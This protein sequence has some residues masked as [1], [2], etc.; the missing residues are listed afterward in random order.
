MIA[1]V[2][3]LLQEKKYALVK[4]AVLEMNAV[5]IAEVFA[6]LHELEAPQTA[7]RL[8][9]LMP[10]ELAAET[11]SYMESD[12]Q[13]SI[14][15]AISDN[16]L[17]FILD[18]M[19]MDDYVDLIEEMPANVVKRVL[20]NSSPENRKLINQY[21]QYPEDSA[22]SLMTNEYVYLKQTLTVNQ[23]LAVIRANGVDKETINKCYVLDD[24]HHLDGVVSLRDLI[25]ADPHARVGDIMRTNVISVNTN[26]DQEEVA[27]MFSKYD[28]LSMPVVD[29]ENRLVGIITID[30]VVD[31]VQDE[32]TEDFEKMAGIVP[33]EDTYLKTPVFTIFRSRIMWLMVLMVS[34]M[35]SGALITHFEGAISTLPILVSFIPMLIGTGCG[36]PGI[37]ASRTIE[38]ERDRRMTIMTTT[39]IPCGAKVPFIGMIAGALFG[40]SA[41]VSTSAYFIGMAAIIISG[42]MLKKTKMFAGDPAPF[43][44]EL[45]AY[46]WPT[47]G[48]VLRSMWERGWSFIK[49]AGT[50]ILLSTI[51]VWFTSR[52][53]W[54]DGQFGMLEEDQISASILAKIG[55]AIAW[56]FAPLG[57]GNWQATVASITGLVAKENIVGTLGILYGGG[58]ASVYANLAQAFTGL[59]GYSFLVFNLLCAPCFAAI[60]AIKREMNNRG[61]T[62]FAIGYQCGFAYCIALMINQFGNL[63]TGNANFLGV[64]VAV[65]FLVGMVY[66]LFKPYKEAAKLSAKP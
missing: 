27:K 15:E 6:E 10:K 66:M 29:R 33:S 21:L 54:L 20:K 40:G 2:L 55:N 34:A 16:E 4:Q 57:W 25:L 14:I 13:Q 31:V 51:F 63:F 28:M 59:A 30:D 45:P 35:V 60:G 49:K 9:R 7:L 5:D 8:F 23:A 18:D 44:M 58:D 39:F 53:G 48:N 37:M 26:D 22:G 3:V 32:A 65:I 19:Y 56:I 11:F 43:V 50:I 61:W 38:N 41:W 24:Q 52:F 64:V 36:I 1:K 47:L 12:V 46:H 17:R 62:W 42:I